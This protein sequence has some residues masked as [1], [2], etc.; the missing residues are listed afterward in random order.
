MNFDFWHTLFWLYK[1][2]F[3]ILIFFKEK[4]WASV[5]GESFGLEHKRVSPKNIEELRKFTKGKKVPAEPR[6]FEILDYD[7]S[8]LH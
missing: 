2:S 4:P 3:D 7:F 1:V 8:L 6:K 5:E